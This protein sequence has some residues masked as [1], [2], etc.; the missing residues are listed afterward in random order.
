MASC[1]GQRVICMIFFKKPFLA[2]C[3]QGVLHFLRYTLLLVGLGISQWVLAQAI[4]S[5]AIYRNDQVGVRAAFAADW[6][7]I[8]S[9]EQAPDVLKPNFPLNKGSNE[10]PLFIGLHANEQLFI[11]LLSETFFDDLEAY[12]EILAQ[13]ISSQGM[14]ITGVRLATD[15]SAMQ[16]DYYH[17]QLGLRFRERVAL[18]PDSQV[19]RMAAWTSRS[20]WDAFDSDVEQAFAAVQLHNAFNAG[21]EWVTVWAELGAHLNPDSIAAV[22][23]TASAQAMPMA[24]A[25]A[26]PTSTMLWRVQSPALAANGSELYLFGSIHMGKPEFYPLAD[27]IESIFDQTDYL[28]F[29]VDPNTAT[30][31]AV[32]VSMQT[33]GMLPQGQSLSDVVSPKVMTDFRRVMGELGLPAENFMSMQPWFLTLM[34]TGL[35]MNALGYLPQYGLESYFL[36]QKPDNAEILELES[37]QEQIGFLQQLNAESYLAYTLKSFATGNA[38]IE[39]LINAWQCADKEPLTNI[40]FADFEYESISASDRADMEAL[41]EALYTRRNVDMA[42]TIAGYADAESGTY[43]VVV[44][45]AHLLGEDSVIS[46]LRDA[47]F[48]VTPVTVSP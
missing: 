25:C 3:P 41:M 4:S 45:S 11:R 46:H 5:S 48:E 35:Q 20:S 2:G 27:E 13:G 29:E 18:L 19:I 39:S 38:E 14:E 36:S 32:I 31:P 6:N 17:P 42:E 10:S 15:E 34:L 26:D 33:R 16:L 30:D 23:L 22:T 24:Q 37:I 43:F 7:I 9:R 28:V 8:T 12:G 21:G 40:L 47:G 1:Y 44:G